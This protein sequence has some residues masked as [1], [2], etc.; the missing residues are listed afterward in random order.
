MGQATFS[1]RTFTFSFGMHISIRSVPVNYLIRGMY[2]GSADVEQTGL[3][4]FCQFQNIASTI[5]VCAEGGF[6]SRQEIG[7][8]CYMNN[9]INTL[10][11][12]VEF[13]LVKTKPA[14]SDI[15]LQADDVRGA[16][17]GSV[18]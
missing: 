9:V 17:K 3:G 4:C 13:I 1:N 12:M 16:E 6:F 10:S 5:Y 2:E 11:K 18:S 8:C 7:D 15:T 14:L